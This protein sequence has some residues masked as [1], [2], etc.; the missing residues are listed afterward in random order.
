MSQE[1]ETIQRIKDAI[2]SSIA[3]SYI[4]IQ[5]LSEQHRKH[6]SVRHL[7]DGTITHLKITIISD[8]FITLSKIARERMLCKIVRDVIDVHSIIFHLHTRDETDKKEALAYGAHCEKIAKKYL[9]NL[10]YTFIKAGYHS[11]YGELDL[12]MSKDNNI[13]FIEVKA[14]KNIHNAIVRESLCLTKSKMRKNSNAAMH[15]LSQYDLY[16]N[17]NIRFDIILLSDYTIFKHIENAWTLSIDNEIIL[18]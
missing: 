1:R 12:I 17:Y 10:N 18:L 2:S 15:F 5:N 11:K 13:V 9:L 14:R 6:E 16:Q 4:D 7:L 3:L 8:E